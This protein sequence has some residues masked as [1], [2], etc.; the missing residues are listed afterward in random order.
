MALKDMKLSAKLRSSFLIIALLTAV[1]CFFNLTGTSGLGTVIDNISTDQLPTV[2]AVLNMRAGMTKILAADRSLLIEKSNDKELNYQYSRMLNAIER[3]E[4]AKNIYEKL[5][6]DSEESKLRS[7][8]L[9]MLQKYKTSHDEFAEL[10]LKYRESRISKTP[11]MNETWAKAVEKSISM[12]ND[13]NTLDKKFSELS[14]N[15]E[16][17]I[18][19]KLQE[20]NNSSRTANIWTIVLSIISFCFSVFLG[21]YILIKGKNL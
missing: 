1:I 5:P 9:T 17:T 6:K 14:D 4:T 11:L 16:T 10:F 21:F 8:V 18:N 20:V 7:E 3:F 12:R 15:A 2:K 19:K 13:F